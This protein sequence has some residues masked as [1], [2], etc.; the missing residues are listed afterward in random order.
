MKK[1]ITILLLIVCVFSLNTCTKKNSVEPNVP[2]TF[3]GPTDP[4]FEKSDIGSSTDGINWTTGFSEFAILRKT[5]TGYMPTKGSYFLNFWA[6]GGQ[7]EQVYQ[8]N[9]SFNSSSKMIF[10]FS[11][12]GDGV[13]KILF[14]SNGT[15]TLWTSGPSVVAANV[16]KTSETITLPALP[17]KGKL[18]IQFSTMTTLL[19]GSSFQIDNIRVQ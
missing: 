11:L 1:I 13:A 12:Q 6:G 4:S 15:A 17:D 14:T 7:I 5:G 8:N 9:V 18:I 10:D 2:I 16:Q 3:Q 19:T